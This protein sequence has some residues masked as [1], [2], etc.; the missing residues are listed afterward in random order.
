M[1]FNTLYQKV[2]NTEIINLYS[3]SDF[4][5]MTTEDVIDVISDFI[6]YQSSDAFTEHSLNLGVSYADLLYEEIKTTLTEEQPTK[7]SLITTYFS[8][9]TSYQK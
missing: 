5:K 7:E 8:L 9:V 6:A 4:V 1:K 2:V 3:E